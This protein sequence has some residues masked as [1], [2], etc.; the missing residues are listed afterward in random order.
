MNIGYLSNHNPLDRN[1]FSGTSYY[2]YRA[3][4]ESSHCSVRMLGSYRRPRRIIDKLYKPASGPG[5]LT[6]KSFDGLDVILSLVSSDLVEKCSPLTEVP[7][8]HCTDATPGFLK[9]FYNMKVPADALEKEYHAYEAASL[10]LFSSD[11]M[12]ERALSEF[13][14]SY[15]PK[16]AAL[17]WGANLDSI[18]TVSPQK[19]P[20]KPLRLLFIGKDWNRK[21]GD[22]VIETLQELRRRGIFAELHL[23]GTKAG[24][25][26]ML[27]N[28]IDHGYLNKNKR[29]DR[30]AIEALLNS[31]HFLILPTRADCTPMVVAEA[32][33]HG[34]P[35]L[36]TDIGGIPS[37][38][39]AG[40]NGEMLSP[41]AGPDDYADRLMALSKDRAQ[42]EA[43]SRSSFEHF[44]ERLT[45]AAWSDAVTR[46][47]KERFAR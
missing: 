44:R 22:V 32:N 28:V 39:R 21:G 46:I 15:A 14:T 47:L 43:L 10:I 5:L 30:L 16:M 7:V 17:P 40:Q 31:S 42:Y 36:I 34:I 2:M 23:V 18:P 11:F 1:A 24:N 4:S 38:M 26:G 19:P 13:G 8:V 9:D 33:S 6:P 3:L 45:W 41:E 25:A 29:K 20:L 35:V 27:E 12:L 37:L